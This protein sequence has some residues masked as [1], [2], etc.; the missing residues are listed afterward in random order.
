MEAIFNLIPSKGKLPRHD[1]LEKYLLEKEG[2]TQT[3]TLRD[4][5]KLSEKMA[6]FSYLFGPVMDCA[7]HG[8]THAGYEGVDKVKARYM[9]EA[10]LC[11]EEVYNEKTKKVSIY[12]ESVSKMGK[13]RLTKFV[14]DA[15]FFLEVELG[16]KVPDSDEWKA[17]LSS[18][19]NFKVVNSK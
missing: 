3:I 13:K 4:T 6:L 7:V 10:E 2:V 14:N 15:L 8:F 1:D 16:Q 5:A 19:R 11:K 9:L 18:G 17:K 12:I